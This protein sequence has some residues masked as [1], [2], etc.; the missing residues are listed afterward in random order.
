MIGFFKENDR[1]SIVDL[2]R[3]TFN[4]SEDYINNFINVFGEN[5]IVCRLND[6]A[7]GMVSLL[8]IFIGEQKGGYIYALAVD[9]KYQNQG[10][11]TR[12]LAFAEEIML[13][14]GCKFSIVVP[15]PYNCLELFYKK[16][17]FCFELSLYTTII[18][19][20]NISGE[21]DIASV[22]KDEYFHVRKAQP[23]IIAHS[24]RFFEYVYDDLILDGF[25]FLEVQND[26]FEGYCV[27]TIK[28][29]CVIIKEAFPV[30]YGDDIAHCVCKK[31]NAKRALLISNNGEQKNPYALMKCFSDTENDVYANLLLDSFG[32]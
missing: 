2:W 9:E 13:K 5:I 4:D 19:S 17:G 7:V 14:K 23:R 26:A 25:Q 21:I 30:E 20:K 32:G 31:F 27:C 8:D 10:I 24:K 12:I 18:Q 15:E 6:R 16:L 1:K 11:A 22:C 3:R 29:D 28:D